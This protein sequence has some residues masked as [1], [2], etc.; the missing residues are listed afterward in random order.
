VKHSDL[1]WIFANGAGVLKEPHGAS[2]NSLAACLGISADQMWGPHGEG[3][4]FYKNMIRVLSVAKPFLEAGDK[5]GWLAEC[6]RRKA[7]AK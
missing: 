5:V 2:V 1:D 7:L 3:F 6:E 4:V